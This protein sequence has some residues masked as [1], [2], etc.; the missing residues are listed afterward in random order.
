MEGL[1]SAP[2]S[3]Y[4]FTPIDSC[5]VCEATP[6]GLQKPK[7]LDRVRQQIR[8]RHY[9]RRTEKSYVG[10]IRR[11]I[12]FHNKRHPAEMGEA[13]ISQFLTHLAVERKVSASTQ[14]QALSALLFLY[15]HV[16]CRNLEWLDG[17]VRAKRPIHLPVVLTP[18]EVLALLRQLSGIEWLMGALLYGTGLRLLECCR[19]RVKDVDFAR[20]EIT[21]RDGKGSK[22]RVTLLPTKIIGPLTVH[23]EKVHAQHT[24][25]LG[26]GAGSVEPAV[27]DRAEV[28]S[29]GVGVGMA[30]GLPGNAVLCGPSDR[31]E[32]ST[33]PPRI[34]SP[35]GC[36]RSGPSCGNCEAG[37]LSHAVPFFC[38]PSLGGRLRHTDYSRDLGSQ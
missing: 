24:R 14:N 23:L 9:S 33:S 19:L 10:W 35:K 22:D 1:R 7:L 21:V 30:M 17:I 15:Q 5:F 36:S 26:S 31:K 38:D 32:A 4:S 37:N 25:D 16:L 27:R 29:R 18:E 34:S 2:L 6:S 20:K 8:A 11:Y 12:L 13:E 3:P 28:S